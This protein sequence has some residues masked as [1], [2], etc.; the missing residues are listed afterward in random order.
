MGEI[1]CLYFRNV[2]E[3][4]AARGGGE[5]LYVSVHCLWVTSGTSLF[6]NQKHIFLYHQGF[7]CK[8][9]KK[10]SFSSALRG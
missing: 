6:K 9:Y 3:N 1:K 5:V 8:N 2:E 10:K 7:F 4:Q